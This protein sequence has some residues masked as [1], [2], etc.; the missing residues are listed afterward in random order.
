[1]LSTIFEITDDDRALDVS[2]NFGLT[3]DST[4]SLKTVTVNKIKVPDLTLIEDEE[5]Y[6]YIEELIEAG[7]D[8]FEP[9]ILE[10]DEERG[11]DVIDGHH[12]SVALRMLMV[13]TIEA[14]VAD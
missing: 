9:V 13:P 8:E 1:M 7:E 12:R 5:S 14:W 3:A 4:Y 2:Y 11:Y 10:G 6:A